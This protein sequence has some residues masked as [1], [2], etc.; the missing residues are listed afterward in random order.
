MTELSLYRKYR[1][2]SFD[3]LIGQ[4][5]IVQS[6]KNITQSGKVAHAYLFSGSRGVGKTSTAR[7]FAKALQTDEKDIYELDAA[8]NRKIENFRE[9]SESVYS[10]PFASKYKVY[11]IDEVHMLTK[12][13]FNAF[14]KTLEEPPAHV[15]FILATTD[16][17]KV[18][19]TVRS[20]CLEFNFK[21][22]TFASIRQAL[23]N[24]AEKEGFKIGDDAISLIG[25]LANGSYR[26]AIGILQKTLSYTEG[27]DITL[28]DVEQ[29]NS[30]PALSFAIGFVECL[31]NKDAQG[32]LAI[33]QEADDAN[34]DFA[35]FTGIV[36]DILRQILLLRLNEKHKETLNQKFTDETVEKITAI[37]KTAKHLNSG[38]I[39]ALIDKMELSHNLGN[40]PLP[41]EI[42]V[43]EILS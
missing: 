23:L 37:A 2:A 21:K 14:L 15:I 8:S 22:A 9:L 39:V 25:F 3:D 10:L 7:I 4:D 17:Q 30:A 26:D 16:T 31:A 42:Y 29:A 1:P 36:L 40:S 33:L 20:R 38:A 19:D 41:L 27:K 34:M 28:Q 6:L 32:A 18:P 13:A 11:I 12:E 43:S 24:I 35:I 5:E